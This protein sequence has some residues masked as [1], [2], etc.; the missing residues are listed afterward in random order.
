[1]SNK[2]LEAQKLVL[3]ILNDFIEDIQFLNGGTKLRASLK[4]GKNTGI[5]DIYINPLEENSFS[6]RFQETNGKLFRLDTYPGE[7]K[8]K[9]L[10]TYPI[11]FHNGSQSNVEEPPF[12]VENNTI[13]NLENFLNFILRLLLGEML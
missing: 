6:F 7:R 10:S 5:L 11:H 2:L 3:K 12:K 1:M 13:Q 9:K 4:A 8:A